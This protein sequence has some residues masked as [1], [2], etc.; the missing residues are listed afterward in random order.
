MKLLPLLPVLAAFALSSCGKEKTTTDTNDDSANSSSSALSSI[1][2]D[3]AP[4]GAVSITEAR[5][6][7]EPG[8]EVVIAGKVMGKL[9]PFVK[10]HALV[11]LGDPAKIT[12][13]DLIPGDE[14]PTPWDV[15]CDDPDVITASIATIQVVDDRGTPVKEGLKGLGGMKELSSLV[16]K[17]T[18][19]EGSNANNFLL[20]ATGIHVAMAEPTKENPAK[21]HSEEPAPAG[22]PSEDTPAKEPSK[23]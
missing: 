19:A 5:K 1:L 9:D 17:G 13:C 22:T 16:V 12:S 10:G 18:V 23:G 11:V 21:G 6:N 3:T 8:T 14:C 15:C 20:N 2:L 4:T 7:P